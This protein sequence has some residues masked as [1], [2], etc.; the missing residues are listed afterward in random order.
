[1]STSVGG[2]GWGFRTRKSPQRLLYA[3]FELTRYHSVIL[4]QGAYDKRE[5]TRVV[6]TSQATNK[7]RFVISFNMKGFFHDN[8]I[9]LPLS[10]P[11]SLRKM[12]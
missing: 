3:Y 8:I 6:G 5:P 9:H 2:G 10:T 11:E 12:P 1:M 4:V 7:N